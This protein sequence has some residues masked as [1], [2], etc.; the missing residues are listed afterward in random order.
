M[1]QVV[2]FC[3]LFLIPLFASTQTWR[4][5]NDS[6]I[7][8]YTNGEFKKAIPFAEKTVAAAKNELGE[9]DINYAHSVTYLGMLYSYTGQNNKAE[10]L[11][12]KAAELYKKISGETHTNYTTSLNSLAGVYQNIGDYNKAEPL[13]I[14]VTAITKKVLGENHP[15]YATSLDK[16]GVLYASTGK[17][18]KAESLYIESIAIRKKVLGE[19]HPDYA[20]SLNNL[21]GLY[22]KKG[23]YEKA[24]SLYNESIAIQKKVLGENHPDYATS[25]NNFAGL[26]M[27]MGKYEKAEQFYIQA[28]TIVKKVLGE[29]HQYYATNMNNLAGL[30]MN[31]GNYKKAEQFYIQATAIIKNVLG[32]NHSYYAGSLQN[33]GL[34]YS[35]MDNYEKAE[36][37]FIQAAAL[38]KQLKGE[39]HPEYATLL[40]NLAELYEDMGNYEKAEQLFIQVTGIK[41]TLLGENHPDYAGSLNSLA[42]LYASIGKYE[43]AEPLFIQATAITKKMLGEAHP[44]YA[45]SLSDMALLYTNM[46]NYEKAEQFFIQA[47]AIGKR[48]LGENHPYYATSLN[49]L[50][51]LYTNMENY[52]KA[53]ELF[54]QTAAITKKALGEN[55][56][57]YAGNLNNLARLYEKKGDYKKAEPVH[58]QAKEIFKTVLGENHPYYATSLNNLAVLYKNMGKYEKAEPLFIQATAIRKTVLGENHPDYATSLTNEAGLYESLGNYEKAEPLLTMGNKIK[59]KN[60]LDIFSTL[61]EKEKGSYLANN[62]SLNNTNNSFLYNNTNVTSSFYKENYNLQLLLKSLSLSDTKNSLEA[63]RNSKDTAINKLLVQWQNDKISLSKQYALPVT[64]RKAG[65]KELETE[66]ENLEKD[67]SRKSSVFRKQQNAARISMKDVQNSLQQDE[68]AIEFVSFK[69]YNKKWTDSTI[70]AAYIVNKKDPVPQF[71]PLFEEKQLQ[72]LLDDSRKISRTPAKFFYGDGVFAPKDK[73]TRQGEAL[74]KLIWQPLEPY[75]TGVKK[76]SYSPAGKLFSIAFHALPVGNDSLLM[77]KYQLQQYTSTRQV[78]LRNTENQTVNP[79]SITL[80]GNA[81]FSMDSVQLTKQSTGMSDGYVSRS[82]YSPSVRA[83]DF[84]PWKS[85]P[86]SAEE[87]NF[88]KQLF[89]KNKIAA[90]SFAQTTASEENLK[91]LNGNSPQILHIATHGFF[92]PDL[93]KAKKDKESSQANVYTLADDPLL[94]TGLILAGGNYAWSGKIPL[95]GVEDG[96]VSAYEIAQ[97]NLSNTELVVLSA[98][99]TALGDVKGSEGV[100]GL[101]RAFKMAGVKKMIVSLWKVPDGETAELMT[102]FYT[103]WMKGKTINDS[104]AQAQADMRKKYSPFYWAAFV[105]ID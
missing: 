10:T 5:L 105:M 103:Y 39:A 49:N 50:A 52:E 32:E 89:D 26:Y 31:M 21:A 90:K 101:Q 74:C 8:Y 7:Y 81:D 80:F 102:A 97:L 71:V 4:E 12:L 19:N 64:S 79:G 61:S 72:Q 78:A 55:S 51:L 28:T 93:N 82:V 16:L 77:E 36:Q 3:L 33:L 56:V 58:I 63:V 75:L 1:K 87:V 23:N 20:T 34:L 37:L 91:A 88:I 17:Y 11:Y 44:Y 59:I 66:T 38:R 57:G 67:L 6:L 47:V 84:E 29:N 48:T 83:G 94:R 86:G 85:L 22:E 13:L 35:H 42:A 96:V 15:D 43:K 30:Y 104:F 99:E 53:E 24:E 65:L 92:L 100:F 41:K 95:E 73:S 69:L 46:G 54:I 70:Y 68:V 27:S 18:E 60:L 62:V 9:S 45:T 14:Q 2:L 98:C 25:L 76:I 40:H